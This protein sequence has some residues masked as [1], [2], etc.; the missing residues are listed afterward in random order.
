M[1]NLYVILAFHAHEMLWD[2]PERL[3]TYLSDDNPM[4]KSF[5]DENYL[6]KRQGEGRDIYTRC[7]ETGDSLG[8]PMCVEYSNEL[9]VQIRDVMP[10]VFERLKQDYHRKRLYPLYG[11]A[12]HT[13]VSLLREGEIPQEINWNRQYLHN[14]MGVPYPKYNGLFPPEDSLKQ[15][16]LQPVARANIDYVIFPHLDDTKVPFKIRGD[17]DCKYNPFIIQSPQKNILALPRNFPVSQEI[18]RPITK[19]KRDEVK[20]QGYM[21]G[22]F[23]VF[24]NEYLYGD[25][26]EYPIT[27]ED[28]ISM[29]KDV[30]L[31]EM[32]NAPDNGLL[33]YIQDLELMDFGDIALDIL[34]EA[35]KRV[36]EEQKDKYN[37]HFVT[38]DEYIDE[39]AAVR[40]IENL[41]VVEFKEI[42]WAPEIRLILRADGHYPPKGVSG[43]DRYD[44]YK[45]GMYEHPHVFWE[46][47]KYYCGLF[48]NLLDNLEIS[49]DIPVSVK[50]L[51]NTEYDIARESLETQAV[52]YSRLMKRA[53]N[54]GWRP[55]EGRQKRPCLLGY[56]LCSVLLKKLEE[57]PPGMVLSREFK[58]PGPNY[59]VGLCEVLKVFID[60]RL[61]YLRYGLDEYSEEK[62]V[63]LS[64]AYARFEDVNKWKGVALYKAGELYKASQE[65]PEGMHR[66]LLLLQEYSQA[67][68]MATDHIQRIWGECP[69][70]EYMVDKMYHYLYEVYPPVFPSMLDRIDSM[71]MEDVQEY[72]NSLT[73]FDFI[74]AAGQMTFGAGDY[75]Q[76]TH[77]HS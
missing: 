39:V 62:G 18:W 67:L 76:E 13:H 35:W 27:M 38:P 47:G 73:V 45:S 63:D 42:C 66:Y 72:F 19:M 55:T 26:E 23:A 9:L 61:N 29:Y 7:S 22:E 20:A 2:L 14:S 17:E 1:K 4:K 37:I 36:L 64:S 3:L 52:L 25:R 60:S 24:D 33:L 6:K 41:P 10:E 57:Y 30:L 53:C 65:G 16:E 48:D 49:P 56:L 5:T 15:D 54:W 32:E 11:H 50:T 70:P 21:L 43:V 8:A 31:G 69:E 12:H 34:E 68:Y 44:V 51:D 28:G 77:L 58:K 71:E 46:N 75:Y 59:F 74:P 40:G